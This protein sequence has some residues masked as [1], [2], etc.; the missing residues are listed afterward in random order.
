MVLL[1]MLTLVLE[2]LG[3]PA[4]AVLVL[5]IVIDPIIGPFRALAIVHTSCAISTLIL[6]KN[7]LSEIKEVAA[8]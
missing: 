5:F 2:P 3:L 7:S 6:P 8:N 4:E 1:S